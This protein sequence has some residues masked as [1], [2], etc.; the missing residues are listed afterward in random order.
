MQA[1]RLSKTLKLAGAIFAF[2]M[3][4]AAHADRLAE[5]KARGSLICATLAANEPLG[6]PDP[7]TRKI[8]GFDV[9]MCEALSRQL[10]LK[11]EH[12]PISVEARVPE[13]TLG[14]VDVVSAAFG[15]TK[16]RAEQVEF[17]ASHYQT[18][19]K[20]VVPV[21][22]GLEKVS[23]LAD[24]KISAIKGSTLEL[25]ARRVLPNATVLTFQDGPTAFLALSQ[26]KVQAMAQTQTGGIR[27]VNETDGKFKFADGSLAWEP[28]ALG[29]KKGEPELLAA[30]NDALE[31]MEKAGVIDTLWA[32]WYGPGTKYNI[33]REKKLTPIA[34]FKS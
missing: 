23:D 13:L 6:F 18:P 21:D 28:T 12:K 3:A 7:Q 24:K 26:G 1:A 9:D 33:V 27:Y 34:T 8:V 2:A 11:F 5:I 31:K 20:L 19:I 10:G 22:S 29:V 30:V 25:F 32:K 16:E 14:R 15:Y 17:T 4:S